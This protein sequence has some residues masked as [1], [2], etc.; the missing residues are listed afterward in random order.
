MERAPEA[1]L[2]AGLADGLAVRRAGRVEAAG[3]SAER[4]P[5][6][7]VMNPQAIRSYSPLL[8]DAVAAVLDEGEFPV[9]L[10]GDCPVPLGTML[11]LRRPGMRW[12]RR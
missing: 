2:G 10:G 9:V 6:T 12:P 1:L 3:Y 5:Q 8:A 11:A 7:K 4:D